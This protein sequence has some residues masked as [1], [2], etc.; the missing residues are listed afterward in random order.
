MPARNV[1]IL[2]Y[3]SIADE[4][5]PLFRRYVVPP[6][7]FQEQMA[8][9]RNAGYTALTVT[10]FVQA[11]TDLPEKPVVLT[12]DDGYR[13]FCTTALPIL[14]QYSLA[15]T[16]YLI[17]AGIGTTNHW[18]AKAGDPRPIMS[19]D[20]V[21]AIRD[22][23]VEIGAHTHTHPH[24]DTQPRAAVREEITTSK[25][26]LEDCLG[27][28]VLSFAYP[29]GHYLGWTKRMVQDAG[30]TSAVAVNL[31]IS[32]TAEDRFA[33]SRFIVSPDLTLD[34]FDALLH[35]HNKPLEILSHRIRAKI[36]WM[37]RRLRFIQD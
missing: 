19:W 10:Q 1:P 22:S 15:A 33:L 35:H 28:P 8:H 7:H 26:L 37:M 3:H 24:L 9:L 21:L 27:Q 34:A 29:Y 5:T 25:R 6:T 18:L 23:G 32:S 11:G 36:W 13:D 2:L 4:A 20:D 17:T 31:E 16:M 14:Q 30:F 12:F